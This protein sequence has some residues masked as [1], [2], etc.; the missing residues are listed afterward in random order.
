MPTKSSNCKLN[1]LLGIITYGGPGLL[2]S[3]ENVV[4]LK[5]GEFTRNQPHFAGHNFINFH[6]SQPTPANSGLLLAAIFTT[7]ENVV[8]EKCGEI[9]Q[10]PPLYTGNNNPGQSKV[11]IMNLNQSRYI[12]SAV[13]VLS[14]K[15]HSW[16]FHETKVTPSK[17]L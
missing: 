12:K 4:R 5:D 13:D 8:R 6:F 10:N 3:G 9:I 14:L 17:N 2:T 11:V 7:G 15:S 1:T 16:N